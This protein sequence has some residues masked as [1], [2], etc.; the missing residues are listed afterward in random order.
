MTRPLLEA[1]APT[2]WV[3]YLLT[4]DAECLEGEDR[5]AADAFL[6]Q[7]AGCRVVGTDGPTFCRMDGGVR[8]ECI[9]YLLRS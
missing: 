8:V 9:V 6:R 5:D 4:G 2:L 7:H 1:A 3:G